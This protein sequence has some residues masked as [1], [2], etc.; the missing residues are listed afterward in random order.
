[1]RSTDMSK[2]RVGGFTPHRDGFV[3]W[4]KGKTRFVAGKST[5]VDQLDDVW[6]DLKR[7]IDAGQVFATRRH[8]GGMILR[9][10]IAAFF[11][12]VDARRAT[13][14]PRPIAER[15]AFNLKQICNDFGARVGG[16]VPIAEIGP[17]HFAAYA[18]TIAHFKAS[19]YASTVSCVRSL[20]NWA[21][22][23]EYTERAR[24]GA[25]FVVPSRQVIRDD[26]IAKPKS[27][28]PADV[29][30][31]I[32]AADHP[33]RAMILLGAVAAMTPSEI[34]NLDRD[35]VDLRG[36][37]IDFR[38]RKTGKIRRVIPLP[39]AVAAELRT[40]VRPEPASAAH[41]G[42]FFIR[43]SGEP[44]IR[45]SGAPISDAFYHFAR[46]VGVKAEGGGTGFSG[47]RTTFVNL[48]PP[49]SREEVELIAGHALGTILF[50]HY[51]ERVG[52]EGLRRVTSHVWKVI[53]TARPDANR[54]SVARRKPA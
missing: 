8:S 12:H 17:D 26:R 31:M 11:T 9:E 24:F 51:L 48:A 45:E 1:M 22:K 42:L 10:L 13:G 23:M 37:I 43:P 20:F 41:A 16:G 34:A 47:L 19:G 38:R 29:R 39:P 35:C 2:K 54:P 53:S 21:V 28:A 4:Y 5:P 30:K 14:K 6:A 25:G 40:Y 3:K 15:T 18:E 7:S 27:F 36:G 52:L 33:M 50:D 44:F 32:G 49:G 46:R